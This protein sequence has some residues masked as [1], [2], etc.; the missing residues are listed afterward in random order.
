MMPPGQRTLVVPPGC[1]HD[2][3]YVMVLETEREEVEKR[4]QEEAEG[5]I[6]E[7]CGDNMPIRIL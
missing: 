1:E 4:I 7:H 3:F 6:L 5:T 2:E